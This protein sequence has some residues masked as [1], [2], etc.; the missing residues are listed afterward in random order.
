MPLSLEK[1]INQKLLTIFNTL[2]FDSKFAVVKTSDRPD[3]SDFQCN[4]ALALAKSEHKNP[5]EIATQIAEELKKDSDF[6]TISVDGPGFINLKVNNSL[7][8]KIIDTTGADERLGCEKIENPKTIVLDFGGPNVAKALHVGHLRSA[9]IGE[10]I[11]RIEEFVG[12]KT[13]SDVHFGDWGTPMGMIIAE[14]IHKDGDL[15]KVET[16]DVNEISAIYKQANIR[17]KEDEEAKE[18]ARQITAKMQDG[19]PEYRKAWQY[20]RDVSVA[21]V[22]KN[23]DE[24]DAHFDLWLGESDAHQTCGDIVKIAEE[25]GVSEVDDGATII[26]LEESNKPKPPVILVKSDGGF[27]YQVTDIATI[28]MRV[29]DLKADEIIYVVDKRQSL[30]FEQVFEVAE[31]L[32]IAPNV[33]L[34]HIGFGTVNGAD[35]KPFKTRD[36][37]VMNLEDLIK[38]SKDKVRE[39]MPEPDAQYN[40]EYIE[41]L[42]AQIAMAAIKFQ[43]LKNNIASGYIFELEDFAKFDGKTG[44]YI[45]YAIARINSILRK[46]GNLKEGNIIITNNEERDLVLKIMQLN[47]VIMR[48]HE[49][50]EPSIISDYAYTLAQ[51]FS[52]FY[53]ASSIMN[54]ESSEI[55]ASRL[56]LARL[57]RDI[58][59]KLLYLL[60]IEAPEVMLKKN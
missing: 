9:V 51:T 52:T 28:K 18:T 56:R 15:S 6:E 22:K 27:A 35:G 58:L 34:Q 46:A 55:A 49:S 42:T 10:S 50:K 5:R 21:A 59:T 19:Y 54:A 16:Y 37:G 53:N 47:N 11:R 13:I 1:T 44:P 48:A 24:L 29:D 57:V 8:G 14:I 2:G 31:K 3:L 36:G 60:G 25:K 43:D 23:Y 38:L 17:C 7:L 30:H 26:R 32:N 20:L 33:K 41:K 45:Q 40:A 12:N 39:S 4:G